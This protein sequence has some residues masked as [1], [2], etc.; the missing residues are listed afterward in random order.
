MIRDVT[1]C[2]VSWNLSRNLS[3]GWD[4]FLNSKF[5]LANVASQEGGNTVQWLAKYIA[6][7]QRS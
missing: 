7:L 3:G 2:N 4:L 5:L 6:G 1:R